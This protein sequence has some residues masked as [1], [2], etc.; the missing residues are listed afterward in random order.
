MR[1]VGEKLE[2]VREVRQFSRV[3]SGEGLRQMLLKTIRLRKKLENEMEGSEENFNS[4]IS[5]QKV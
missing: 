1:K 4:M 2:L 3:N 5:I